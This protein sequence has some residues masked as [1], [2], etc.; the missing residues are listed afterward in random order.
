[1]PKIHGQTQTEPGPQGLAAETESQCNRRHSSRCFIVAWFCFL[2]VAGANSLEP[3]RHR[4]V[5]RFAV[6]RR[7]RTSPWALSTDQPIRFASP[8]LWRGQRQRAIR[9]KGVRDAEGIPGAFLEPEPEGAKRWIV[10]PRCSFRLE[11]LVQRV[12]V[13]VVRQSNI[14]PRGLACAKRLL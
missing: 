2:L 11:Y 12:G 1:M 10:M 4:R 3:S 6:S 13:V 7:S 14:S 5:G 9:R 8:R